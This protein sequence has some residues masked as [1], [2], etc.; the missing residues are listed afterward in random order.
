MTERELPDD[1][2]IYNQYLYVIRFTGGRQ[3]ITRAYR[4]MTAG[5]FKAEL[6]DRHGDEGLVLTNCDITERG[7]WEF[8]V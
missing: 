4:N 1:Y 8:A 3:V 2:P 5:V 7:L 6:I